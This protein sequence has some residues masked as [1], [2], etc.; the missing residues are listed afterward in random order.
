MS[1]RLPFSPN[2]SVKKEREKAARNE[3]ARVRALRDFNEREI[4]YK[5]GSPIVSPS[6][7]EK[8]TRSI[9]T[10]HSLSI[11]GESSRQSIVGDQLVVTTASNSQLH[12]AIEIS[13]VNSR[14][15][16]RSQL[17]QSIELVIRE[18]RA[19][20]SGSSQGLNI[21]HMYCEGICVLKL[22]TPK[23]N[24]SEEF[25]NEENNQ[26][27]SLIGGGIEE[28]ELSEI[29]SYHSRD[30]ESIVEG[31]SFP[32]RAT[33]CG[34][35]YQLYEQSI[36][37]QNINSWKWGNRIPCVSVCVYNNSE[38]IDLKNQEGNISIGPSDHSLSSEEEG[39]SI[40]NSQPE[41]DTV[42][43]IDIEEEPIEIM[44]DP[45]LPVNMRAGQ[46]DDRP[47]SLVPLPKFYSHIENDPDK[48]INE[49][50][51][52]C[53]ANNARTAVYWYAIFQTMLEDH[54]KQ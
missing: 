14:F 13:E 38:F 49:F 42:H 46:P 33:I 17:S 35:I 22:S 9:E 45:L 28:S 53:N 4:K 19:S 52:A 39:S 21:S 10:E 54:A 11:E 15:V 40:D 23:Q 1:Y 48:H 51:T 18:L 6:V 44:E 3:S 32:S 36:D 20:S 26:L 41:I 43:S 8:S 7:A 2:N 5:H 34:C 37:G 47:I 29:H 31:G 25:Q 27:N 30:G 50:L 16:G 24:F 12:P